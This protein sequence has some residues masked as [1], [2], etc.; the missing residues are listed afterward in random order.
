MSKKLENLGFRLKSNNM[1]TIVW[2][3][4][5]MES[6]EYLVF[7]NSF[8]FYTYKAKVAGR[9]VPLVMSYE[10]HKIIDEYIKKELYWK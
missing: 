2:V 5:L 6:A 4:E 1:G 9:E 8:Q 3:K 7:E 10:I